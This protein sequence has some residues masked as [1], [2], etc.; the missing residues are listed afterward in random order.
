MQWVIIRDAGS[1]LFADGHDAAIAGAGGNG[2]GPADWYARWRTVLFEYTRCGA[3]LSCGGILAGGPT[4]L[5][6]L[7]YALRVALREES[8]RRRMEGRPP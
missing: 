5:P 2:V 6:G 7:R 3:G 1:A 8:T 4:E